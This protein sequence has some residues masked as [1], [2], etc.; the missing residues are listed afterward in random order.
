MTNKDFGKDVRQSRRAA[1]R[2][3]RIG[4][5]NVALL[6]AV[7]A[8]AVTLVVTPMVSDPT[9]SAQMALKPGSVDTMS[10]GSITSSGEPGKRYTIRRSV[11]QET[12]G[13]VCIVGASAGDG[14]C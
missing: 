10:T 13:A 1:S 8:V 12:P 14:G 9:S 11:L 2:S 6:F 5:V 4:V 3:G 7:A